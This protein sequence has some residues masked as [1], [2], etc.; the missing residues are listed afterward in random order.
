MQSLI[1]F[2]I[3]DKIK[4]LEIRDFQLEEM[5]SIENDIEEAREYL[6]NGQGN[7]H[8]QRLIS[9]SNEAY[10]IGNYSVARALFEQLFY[11]QN[12]DEGFNKDSLTTLTNLARSFDALESCRRPRDC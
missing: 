8:K 2:D 10:A 3:V 5:Y 7:S 12:L 6:K 9:S 4:G 11:I 1:E